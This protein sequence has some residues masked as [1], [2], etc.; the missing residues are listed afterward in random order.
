MISAA[1]EHRHATQPTG[2]G[3]PGFAAPGA[4]SSSAAGGRYWVPAP[5]FVWVWLC[6]W[7][8]VCAGSSPAMPC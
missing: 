3:R 8:C 4:A 5:L 7:L 6:V 2:P 1:L